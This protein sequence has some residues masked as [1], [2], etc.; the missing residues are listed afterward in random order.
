MSDNEEEDSVSDSEIGDDDN[1]IN[2]DEFPNHNVF[3][4]SESDNDG[5]DWDRDNDDDDDDEDNHVTPASS[6]PRLCAQLRNNDPSVLAEGPNQFF[7]P[8]V[9]DVCRL[10]IAEALLE[11]T[12]VR[13]IGLEL[14]HY[15]KLSA[16]AMAKY[17]AQ[18]KHLLDV[19]LTLD[20]HY[21]I[22]RPHYPQF[23][24]TF[25]EAISQSNSVQKLHL[26][27]PGLGPASESFENLLTRTKT[28][29]HLQVELKRPFPREEAATAAIASG[30]SNNTTLR[31]IKLIDWQQT[32][33][34][35]ALAAL[36]DHPEL[37]KLHVWGFSSF[38]GIDALLSGKNCQLK[39][40]L[41]VSFNGS[42]ADEGVA[43]FE[44]FMLEMGRNATILKLDI[45]G[46][47][48]LNRDNT[49]QLTAM[50]RRN[51]VL[52]DLDLSENYLGSAGF[53]EIA[54]ALYRN[55]SI[56]GLN[57]SSNELEDLAAGNTLRELLRRNKTITELSIQHNKFGGYIDVVRCIADGFRANTTLQVIGLSTCELDDEGL[58]IL[59]AGFGQQKR[60][61]V[62]LNLSENRITCSGLRALVN[63]AT[64]TLSALT[65]LNL[66]NNYVL[67]EGASFLA[68]TLRLQT[69]PSLTH[70]RL[71]KCGISDDGLVALMLAL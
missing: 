55:T 32:G 26:E 27:C 66:T 12:I 22:D 51:A 38:T 2:E 16:D 4:D 61:L 68:E 57:V 70:I 48:P 40:L 17:L 39:E 49:Q 47:V 15:N 58:S 59:A 50:L 44:S 60:S 35:P 63:H 3:S 28:L 25:F 19:E 34:T 41:I 52:Q 6:V 7:Q 24:P 14:K 53:A 36:R 69:L 8:D 29:R 30:F 20:S 37:E 1:G 42:D 67:D 11:N 33:L 56:Q 62:N 18:S 64:A 23:L 65:H 71:F 13:R 43:G 21:T 46:G 5:F 31:D 54:S 10:Q 9:L 45:A